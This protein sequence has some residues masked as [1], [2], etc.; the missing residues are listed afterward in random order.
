MITLTYPF[1]YIASVIHARLPW[2]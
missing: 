1:I 2:C